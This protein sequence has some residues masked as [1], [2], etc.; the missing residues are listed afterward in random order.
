MK[1]TKE[2]VLSLAVRAAELLLESGAEIFRVEDTV[3]RLCKASGV[4]TAEVFALPTGIFVSLVP[5]STDSHV[6]TRILRVRRTGTDLGK[7]H[8][9]NQFA[10]TFT[11][12]DMTVAEGMAELERIHKEPSTPAWLSV[13][14][15]GL[16]TG[17]FGC[18]L[19][20]DLLSTA[21][22]FA[23]GM[24]TWIF[25]LCLSHFNVNYVISRL[26]CCSGAAG[27]TM[28]V[29][30]VGSTVDFGSTIIGV[31]MLYARCWAITASVRDLLTGDMLSGMSRLMEAILISLSC[32][33]GVGVVMKMGSLSGIGTVQNEVSLSM[34]LFILC[35]ALGILGFTF[36]YHA[37][38]HTLLPS[39][40]IGGIACMVYRLTVTYLY[41][42]ILAAF[43]ASMTV[44]LLAH[45]VS[46]GLKTPTT[47][48][49]VPSILPFVPG[50]TI[51]YTMMEL[52]RGTINNGLS[53]GLEAFLIAGALALG[54]LLMGSLIQVVFK[55]THRVS[56]LGK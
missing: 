21:L 45:F 39:M 10:R 29:H 50:A 24:I 5:D 52:L 1:A 51:Y 33:T 22:A 7:L 40:F 27:L 42:P 15:A 18:T 4:G 2:Q 16:A 53:L 28:I 9:I 36:L 20:G 48:F 34:G 44:A 37:P 38:L 35:G 26:L 47:V 54:L 14:A 43:L 13:L 3:Q 11:E 31:L 49:V 41:G 55:L 19:S 8:K 25:Y 23:I 32:A 30:R 56:T 12:T 46:R 17:A 6:R